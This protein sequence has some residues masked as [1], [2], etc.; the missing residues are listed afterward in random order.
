MRPPPRLDQQQGVRKMRS[1]VQEAIAKSLPRFPYARSHINSAA[2]RERRSVDAFAN[3]TMAAVPPV[4][5]VHLAHTVAKLPY[6]GDCESSR[7][8]HRFQRLLLVFARAIRAFEVV[9]ASP[10][11]LSM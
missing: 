3:S 7:P 9:P 10:A 5:V 4:E 1:R 2:S 11:L 6:W 8:S